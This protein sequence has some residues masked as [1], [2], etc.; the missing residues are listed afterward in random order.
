MTTQKTLKRRVR[1][2][3]AKT[4]ESYTTARAQVL[5][6]A[7]APD[8]APDSM[9]LAGVS[10]EAMFRGTGKPLAEWFPLLDAWGASE[11]KHT[12]IAR[13]LVNE[14]GVPGWWAQSVTVAWERARG[15]RVLHQDPAGFSISVSKTVAAPATRVSDAWT[16][17][18]LRSAWLPDAPI[19]VRRSN[20]GRSARFDWDEPPSLVGVM[21]FAKGDAKTQISLGHEKLP[22]AEAAERLKLMWR[23]R[24]S[25]LKA[26]LE[27]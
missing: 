2:R 26:M 5:R 21:L 16:D 27:G 10:D 1:A 23:E 15:I 8:P 22:D 19:R 25:A 24:L 3:A 9:A 18:S 13:W 11:H 14:H 20:R 17:A 12:E 7:D 6:K 4:G